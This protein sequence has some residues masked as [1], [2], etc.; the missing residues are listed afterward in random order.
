MS[1]SASAVLLLTLLNLLPAAPAAE[2][3]AFDPRLLGALAAR[4]IGPANMGGRVT[5]V[6]VVENSP[7]TMYLAAATGGVWKT[8][9]GGDTWAAVFDDQDTASVGAVAV[10][11]SNPEIVWVGTGEANP[12]NSVVGGD[13]V[14]KSTDG[15]K[16]W[17]HMGLKDSHHVGRVL[18]HPKDPDV[19]YVAALGHLWGPNKERG[20][21]KTADGGRTWEHAL[22]LDEDTG[23]ADVALD[24][25]GPDTLLAAAWRVRR[26]GF[27]G[28][29]PATQFGDR[30]GLYRTTDG[31]KT[32]RRLTDGLP[33]RPLGRCG[34][35]FCRKDPRVVYA[36]IQTDRTRPGLAGGPP[37][38]G[39]DADTGG[40]FRS[41][42]GGKTWAK[43][44]DLCPRPFYFGQVRADPTSERRVYVLGVALHVSADGG[45]NFVPGAAGVHADHHALWVN[46][47]D[48][49]HLVLGNDGGLYF[50]FDHGRNWQPVRNLALGQ[51]YA[52]AADTRR[53]YRVYGG[54]QDNGTWG[55]PS[56]TRRAD[57]VTL[58]DWSKVSEGDG[59]QCAA[60]P[61]DPDVV[62]TEG[63]YGLLERVNVRTRQR[64]NIRPRPAPGSPPYRFNWCAPLLLSPHDP[65]TLYYGGNHLFRSRDRGDSWAVIS[66][67]LTRGGPGPSPHTG[68]TLTAVAESPLKAGLL[69]AGSDDGRLHVTRDGGKTWDE[70]SDNVP[71]VPRDLWVTRVECSH[72]AEG[73]AY[74]ALDRRRNDD[75]RPYVFRTTDHGRTWA[76]LTN[77]L[78]PAGPVHVV[79]ASSRNPDLLFAG[80]DRGLFVT[81]D[82]GGRWHRVRGGL[83][84]VPVHDLMIHPRD[85]E[86]VIGTHGRSVFVMDVAPLEELTPRL[87]AEEVH[88]F[89]VKPATAFE[90]G[91]PVAAPPRSYAAPDPPF[92]AVIYYYLREAPP[93][94]VTLTV[95]S[96]GGKELASLPAAR[97]A[98]LHR[99]VWDLRAA[100]RNALAR[101]GDYTIRLTAGE[102]T[103]AKTVRVVA[104][105]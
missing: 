69:Y 53:P 98:G 67:D 97:E 49:R 71:G 63:Q 62:Y 42:D 61:A 75:L 48:P 45:R 102:R 46:P 40:V 59:F 24:P 99:A 8:A 94:P 47:K 35:D 89:D 41:L 73:T 1:R 51:F 9:D 31:G 22:A 23:C 7:N 15:G 72:H 103:L 78:P 44:N 57:G 96:A 11:P 20:L 60:D 88:L 56:A 82:G 18:I 43:L 29:D 74:L 55:G 50:S 39:R 12:R 66:P 25:S 10:A 34:I 30:A 87:L 21:F 105:E 54:L 86:L 79:R 3:P 85:R 14:Y 77:G 13:G 101:P 80:T 58:A 26:G 84:T 68:H 64:S 32:W 93:R 90:A 6:A 76:P 81:A 4:P 33:S 92:G 65:K 16:T 27:S 70:L 19:V 17:K 28:T 104:A 83:P 52:V 36:V 38:E 2:P 91:K 100:G 95:L 37:R 5:D